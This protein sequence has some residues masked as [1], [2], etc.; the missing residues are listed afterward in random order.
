[1]EAGLER[2]VVE[3]ERLEVLIGLVGSVP[4][5]DRDDGAVNMGEGRKDARGRSDSGG[6]DGC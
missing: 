5:L 1:M 3:F 2:F 4:R 6:A